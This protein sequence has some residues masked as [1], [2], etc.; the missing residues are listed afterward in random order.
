[1]NCVVCFGYLREKNKCRGCRGSDTNKPITRKHCKIKTCGK[2]NSEFCYDCEDFPCDK[3]YHL[4]MRY[5]T[6]YHMSVIENL[7]SVKT[8]GI[9]HFLK[10]ENLLFEKNHSSWETGRMDI[11]KMLEIIET[12]AWVP[13]E[14]AE[15]NQIRLTRFQTHP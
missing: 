5:R 9:K 6:K 3:L 2:L 14:K 4:D 11:E 13:K 12:G 15:K 7:K 10:Q 1:M 8:N